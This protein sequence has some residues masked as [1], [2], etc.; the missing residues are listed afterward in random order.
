M[1]VAADGNGGLFYIVMKRYA[2]RD[3]F[4]TISR[5]KRTGCFF[6]TNRQTVA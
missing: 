2:S 5:I 4:V 6:L 1:P 3:Y